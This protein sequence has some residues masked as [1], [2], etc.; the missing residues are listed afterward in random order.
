MHYYSW[1]D[2]GITQI[3]DSI[4]L[5]AASDQAGHRNTAITLVYR[6]R[7]RINDKVQGMSFENVKELGSNMNSEA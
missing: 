4:G 6:H 7:K 5:L 2:T 1:K 3:I